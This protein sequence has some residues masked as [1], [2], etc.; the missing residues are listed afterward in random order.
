VTGQDNGVRRLFASTTD[1][2]SLRAGL[3]DIVHALQEE[4]QEMGRG[5]VTL[6]HDQITPDMVNAKGLQVIEVVAANAHQAKAKLKAMSDV[7][8]TQSQ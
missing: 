8:H 1:M 5:V 2:A 3:R 4:V 7:K 6:W